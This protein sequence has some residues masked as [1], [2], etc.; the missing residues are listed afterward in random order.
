MELQDAKE[1]QERSVG[2]QCRMYVK[3]LR[4]ISCSREYEYG[5][6]F[7]CDVDHELLEVV[8]DM[9]LVADAVTKTEFGKGS[10]LIQKYS[11]LLPVKGTMP[12]VSLGEG[13]TPLLTGN[14]LAESI[15]LKRLYLKDETRNPSGTFKDRSICVGVNVALENKVTDVSIGSS[16]NAGASLAIY[17]A[18]AGIK[19]WII[20]PATASPTKMYQ[21][22]ACG[23]KVI[24][25]LAPVDA[26]LVLLRQ[27]YDAWGWYPIPTSGPTNPY[28]SEGA[29]TCA[30]EISSQLAD[31]SPDWVF[32]P[33][34]GGDNIASNWRAFQELEKLDFAGKPP[35]L[36]GVQ[37]SACE[38]LTEPLRCGHERIRTISKPQTIAS[39]ICM[40][41]PPTGLAALRAIRQSGGVAIAVTDNEML[42]AQALLASRE[43]IFAEPASASVVAALR[44]LVDDGTVASKDNV[45]CVI[46]GTGLK[47]TASLKERYVFPSPIPAT[48]E[49][50]ASVAKLK[51]K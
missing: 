18:R 5:K 29:K 45:V 39:S 2:G 31:Q 30:Y 24:P 36:V 23:A 47:E 34:G 19:C 20:V 3:A 12:T 43:G 28:Q 42:E 44:Q 26:A 27:A 4:C 22:M 33:V 10:N 32:Y 15:G 40:E 7:M 41:H 9:D 1:Q 50:L 48:M 35:K 17:S 37:A 51:V 11:P 13:D 21:G 38:S 14:R 46:T 6:L 49:G 25:I 16:G 8:Y